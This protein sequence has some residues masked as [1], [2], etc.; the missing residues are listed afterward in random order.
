MK[1][2]QIIIYKNHN[3]SHNRLLIGTPTRGIVRM[4]WAQAR[5]GQIIPTNWQAAHSSVGFS[6]AFPLGYLVA[7][8]Q[9]IIVQN[10]IRDDYEWLLLHE[11]DVVLPF[12]AFPRL[13]EYM[14][15]RDIPV[16]SGLYC[17]KAAPTEPLVYRGR[18]NSC[19]SKFKMGDRVWCDGVPT[20]CLL[21]HCSILKL[22]WDESPD[23]MTGSGTVVRKVFETPARAIFD[24]E[25]MTLQ[26]ACGTSDLY[27]CDRVMREDVLA[28]AGWKTIGRRR[29]P[30]L[31]DTNIRCGHIDLTSGTA[32]PLGGYGG[33]GPH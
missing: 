3:P 15:K 7:D 26:Q 24:P 19:Y 21:I 33:G 30:F 29:W 31:V 27:W 11:D 12:D 13:N 17:L 28:R 5:Y 14:K 23:Y 32:Y 10:A 2:E 18:G 6:Q 25:R 1:N 16:V 8:A 20:G 4:E 22:M 9:N